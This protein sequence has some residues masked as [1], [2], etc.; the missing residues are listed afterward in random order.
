[1]SKT[2]LFLCVAVRV[3][4]NLL[5]S[6]RRKVFKHRVAACLTLN[7][8][9]PTMCVLG[10]CSLYLSS[11]SN[12]R[13]QRTFSVFKSSCHLLLP[14]NHSNVETENPVMC[15]A[16]GHKLWRISTLYL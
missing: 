8:F 4:T 15:L 10:S 7:H 1:M 2:T 16:Q 13:Q 11:T 6:V 3:S 12:R 5:T 9:Y 14:A